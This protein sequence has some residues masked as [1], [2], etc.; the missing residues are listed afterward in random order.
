MN[1]TYLT[2]SKINDAAVHPAA[3]I[4][5]CENRYH[6]EI[7]KLAQTVCE[8]KGIKVVMI[9]GPSGS[10]KTTTSKILTDYLAE[11]GISAQAVSLDDFYLP[12][13]LLPVL[14]NGEVD[15]ES[16]NSLDIEL[17]REFLKEIIAS[18]TAYM[19]K[20]TFGVQK[21][22]LN[23]IR[24]DVSGAG[25]LIVEGLHALNPLITDMLGSSIYKVYI[26][27]AEA[28]TLQSGE[29]LSSKKIRFMRRAIRDE[30]FR[31]ADLNATLKQWDNV[32]EGEEKYL[33]PNKCYA[34]TVLAT[35]HPYEIGVYKEHFI[36]LVQNADKN[37]E[38]YAY[39]AHIAE[40]IGEFNAVDA[41]YIPQN[42][43]I[44]E[45]IGDG[46]YSY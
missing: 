15:I 20:Y 40:M 29:K 35:L 44:R 21:R 25:V 18:G 26:S 23:A 3:F 6:S 37:G 22:E 24:V 31:N 5:A 10:G 38:D 41:G 43:L 36:G 19:P 34:D 4:E 42:S 9:A 17:L 46:K 11:K 7:E 12:G 13:E 2:A 1:F 45:F 30:K 32:L 16:V 27:V 28:I 8:N 14:E 33:Y 39:A